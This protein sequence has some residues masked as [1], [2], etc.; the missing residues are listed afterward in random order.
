LI[1]KIHDNSDLHQPIA[2][3]KSPAFI[4]IKADIIE[5]VT[6]IPQGRVTTYGA[7]GEHL[8]VMAR[9]VAYIL[10]TLQPVEQA[11]IP[12]YRVVSNGGSISSGKLN[13]RHLSQVTLLTQEGISFN[14]KNQIKPEQ[15]AELFCAPAS[16]VEW[17]HQNGRYLDR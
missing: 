1:G 2:M 5:L 13:A 12:W 17:E 15:F 4:Q 14:I 3:P 8:N 7:I 16:L 6:K 11:E 9:H 10:A